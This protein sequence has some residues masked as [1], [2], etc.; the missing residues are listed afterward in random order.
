MAD[1]PIYGMPIL[2]VDKSGSVIVLKRSMSS[3]FAGIDNP[4][5]YD[6]KTAMLF[7][8]AKVERAP[9]SSPRSRLFEKISSDMDESEERDKLRD[10]IDVAME[11][12][13]EAMGVGTLMIPD[14]V[15]RG[16]QETTNPT[17]DVD[18]LRALRDDLQ[19]L[20]HALCRTMAVV[21]LRG[22]LKT[23]ADGGVHRVA[24]ATVGELLQE[25]ERAKPP[26]DGWIL[27]ERDRIRRHINVFVN[28]ERGRRGHAGRPATTRST[29][30][31]RSQE[32]AYDRV[33]GRDQEGP[34]RARGRAGRRVRGHRRARSPASRSSTRCATRTR[35]RY[36]GRDDVAVLRPEDLLRDDQ[37]ASGSRRA[38][39]SCPR[40][41]SRRSSGSG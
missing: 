28:G 4:L 10:E 29:S 2:D 37:T 35:G 3:G 31:P 40:A 27:D 34:V 7:G 17:L 19:S 26:L 12:V 20:L 36:P 38:A 8:D 15:Q 39:S 16:M 18:G 32:A 13:M 9:R 30:C 22:P 24:G 5:F 21:L 6:P 25:L 33:A 1:S 23:L 11:Q 41:A 14:E